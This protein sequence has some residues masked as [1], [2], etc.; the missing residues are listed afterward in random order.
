MKGSTLYKMG[1]KTGEF[2]NFRVK[3]VVYNPD[4]LFNKGFDYVFEI[5]RVSPCT[6]LRAINPR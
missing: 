1:A 4:E 3:K 2:F 5:D 6:F